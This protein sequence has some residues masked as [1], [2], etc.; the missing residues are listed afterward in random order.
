[1]LVVDDSE[2]GLHGL[3]L[4]VWRLAFY[5]LDDG[6]AQTPDVGR[7]RGARKLDDLWGHPVWGADDAGLVQAGLLRRHTKVSQLDEALLGGEDV[8]ALDVTVYDTLLVEVEEAV[9][10]LRHVQ[11]HEVFGELSKVFADGVQGPIF[12]VPGRVS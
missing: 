8:G 6:T 3:Q 12:A 1:M 10:D 9:K 7:C 2:E 5:E 11:G 4:V